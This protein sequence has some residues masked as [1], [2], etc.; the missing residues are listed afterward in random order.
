M[1][2]LHQVNSEMLTMADPYKFRDI[3]RYKTA[4][5]FGFS[6]QLWI[7]IYIESPLSAVINCFSHINVSSSQH[8]LKN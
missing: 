1:T 7:R 5:I 2:T 8:L 4:W 6:V 3:I